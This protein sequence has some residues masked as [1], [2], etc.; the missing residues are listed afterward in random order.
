MELKKTDTFIE[1]DIIVDNTN[2]GTVELC[3][4]RHEISRLVIFEPLND[5][6]YGQ[7]VALDLVIEELETL[8]S[9]DLM[10]VKRGEWIIEYHGNGW[11]DYWDYTCSVCGKKFEK[12][13]NVLYRA[14]FC[15]NC[16]CRM[17]GSRQ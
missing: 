12:A 14:K 13:D 8:P 6:E 17:K 3:P 9:A 7:N 4:E 5:L 1:H 2:V 11:N 16:G 15:P 10:E